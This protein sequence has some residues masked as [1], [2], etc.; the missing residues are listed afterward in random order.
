MKILCIGKP[1]EAFR[2][3]PPNI[4]LQLLESFQEVAIKQREENKIL[5]FY[6]TPIGYSIVILNYENADEWVRDQKE[7]PIIN[8][9][10]YTSCVFK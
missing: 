2:A 8:Y 4:S 9:C 1:T 10:W 7:I 3:L 5:D 6:A